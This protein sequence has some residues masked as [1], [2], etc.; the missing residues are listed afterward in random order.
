MTT[1]RIF[2]QLGFWSALL[3]GTGAAAYGLMSILIG[4]TNASAIT[5]VDVAEFSARYNP[6]PTILILT[7][8]FL[9]TLAYPVLAVS[10][11]G[12]APDLRKPFGMLAIVFA[13][14][15]SAVLGPAYWMQLT[16][17]PQSVLEGNAAAIEFSILWHTRSFF[18]AFESFGYF[19]IGVSCLFAGLS[20]TREFAASYVKVLLLV[21]APLGILFLI[22]QAAGLW[23]LGTVVSLFLVFAWSFLFAVI[24]FS[25]A[26]AC[27]RNFKQP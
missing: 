22:N 3:C 17:V 24:G 25:L 10:L 14:I 8:P 15:Y 2:L 6:L 27:R 20:L 19:A 16:F 4:A 21:L 13:A 5:W 9:V 12:L 18:W 1:R 23:A 11:F 7:P 26:R